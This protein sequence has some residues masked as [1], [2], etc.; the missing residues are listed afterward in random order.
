MARPKDVCRPT[1]G[2]DIEPADPVYR[3]EA[4]V[5]HAARSLSRA[6]ELSIDTIAFHAHHLGL[7]FTTGP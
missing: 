5:G 6:I 7:T 4:Q 1:S 3:R 2:H